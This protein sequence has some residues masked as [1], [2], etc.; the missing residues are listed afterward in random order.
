MALWPMIEI[1][2]QKSAS[3]GQRKRCMRNKSWN[4]LEFNGLLQNGTFLYI[5]V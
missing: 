4:R 2:N 1:L 5:M 3:Y